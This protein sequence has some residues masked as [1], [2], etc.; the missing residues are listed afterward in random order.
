MLT[1]VLYTLMGCCYSPRR[2]MPVTTNITINL[3]SVPCDMNYTGDQIASYLNAQLP[4]SVIPAG[5]QLSFTGTTTS[6]YAPCRKR[7]ARSLLVTARCCIEYRW[8]SVFRVVSCIPNLGFCLHNN[9]AL[10]LFVSA[11]TSWI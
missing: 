9:S 2:L 11:K 4:P 10:I 8:Y 7:L 6:G 3:A 5:Q 1:D